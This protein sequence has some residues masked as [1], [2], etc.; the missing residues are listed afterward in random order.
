MDVK[1][2]F[3][4]GFLQDDIYLEQSPGLVKKDEEEKLYKIRKA[5]YGLKQFP[6][7]WYD[8]INNFFLKNGFERCSF[9]H[10]LYMKKHSKEGFMIVS[11]YVDDLIFTVT[12]AGDVKKR[13]VI[14][15]W[16][17]NQGRTKKKEMVKLD[18][19]RS[20]VFIMF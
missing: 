13:K 17:R 10:T 1:S 19:L 9:E 3:L 6:R 5:L 2:A 20:R 16:L 4:N 18:M 7:A 12:D 15:F 14:L 8:R 11:L